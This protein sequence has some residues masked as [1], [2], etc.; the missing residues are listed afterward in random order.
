MV[1]PITHCFATPA[2]RPV[3]MALLNSQEKD[4]VDAVIDTFISLS[5]TFAPRHHVFG[6][7]TQSLHFQVE[8]CIE[9]LCDF[10]YPLK[11]RSV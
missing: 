5:L 9:A 4:Q 3:N 2:V 8:P 11:D 10:T 1:A 6:L 7:A